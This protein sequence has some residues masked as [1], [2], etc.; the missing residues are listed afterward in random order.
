MRSGWSERSG[1]R[2]YKCFL[3]G[4]ALDRVKCKNSISLC[5]AQR[6]V[7][8]DRVQQHHMELLGTLPVCKLAIE[9]TK[10]HSIIAI[11][12]MN[13]GIEPE[14]LQKLIPNHCTNRTGKHQFGEF[15]LGVPKEKEL[16]RAAISPSMQLRVPS[17]CFH[18]IEFIIEALSRCG[19]FLW[20]G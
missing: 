19:V 6:P 4:V 16:S 14:P 20:R 17:V 8:F 15:P 18:Q 7:L 12:C 10:P 5:R 3:R 1:G 11:F 9:H 13:G 2:T